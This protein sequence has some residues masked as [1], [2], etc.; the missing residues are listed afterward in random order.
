M[1]RFVA[2]VR[3]G[4]RAKDAGS[5]QCGYMGVT[6]DAGSHRPARTGGTRLIVLKPLSPPAPLLER[7]RI[8]IPGAGLPSASAIDSGPAA[9]TAR[10]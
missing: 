5:V 9:A 7:E 4:V 2:G 6:E 1:M 10:C 3:W 8:R